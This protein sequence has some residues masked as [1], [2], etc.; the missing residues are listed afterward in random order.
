MLSEDKNRNINF[1]HPSFT[2]LFHSPLQIFHSPMGEPL[3]R[4]STA[5]E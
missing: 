5:I 3:T 4:L 2:L 1:I